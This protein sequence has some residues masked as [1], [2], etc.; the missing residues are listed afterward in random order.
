M[1]KTRLCYYISR[2][3]ILI[4]GGI[5]LIEFR[6]Y[7]YLTGVTS[8]GRTVSL[9]NTV[10]AVA[11]FISQ[12]GSLYNLAVVSPNGDSILCTKGKDIVSCV[13]ANFGARIQAMVGV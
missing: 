9:S 1:P 7:T 3:L 8:S 13:D 10:K 2:L 6:N 11:D 12:A 4:Q 5:T